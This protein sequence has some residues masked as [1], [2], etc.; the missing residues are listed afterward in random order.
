MMKW[1]MVFIIEMSPLE[2]K[3]IGR[4]ETFEQCHTEVVHQ[5]NESNYFAKF[6]CIGVKND[7]QD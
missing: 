4:Y 7:Q 5:N 3:E 1:L 2:Y 6:A